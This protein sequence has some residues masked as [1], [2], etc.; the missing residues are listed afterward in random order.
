M[1]EEKRMQYGTRSLA[2]SAILVLGLGGLTGCVYHDRERVATTP[3]ATSTVVV[4][5][6]PARQAMQR[7]YTYPE[8]RYELQ[9]TGTSGDP[10]YWVWIPNGVQ[11][12]PAI[13]RLPLVQ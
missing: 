8:G 2:L 6:P 12:V 11:S 10:Y 4:A 1:R 9:G 5:Q 3:P 13:P 7:V